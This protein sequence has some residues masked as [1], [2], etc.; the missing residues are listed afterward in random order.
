MQ[1]NQLFFGHQ[2]FTADL[3]V[4]MFYFNKYNFNENINFDTIEIRPFKNMA[5]TL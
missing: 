2:L 5:H 4:K 1:Y 3:C